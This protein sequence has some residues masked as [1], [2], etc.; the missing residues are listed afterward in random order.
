MSLLLDKVIRPEIQQLVRI[1]DTFEGRFD[2]LRL[3]KNECLQPFDEQLLNQFRINISSQDLSG[4]P[5]LGPL[6]RKLSQFVGVA[7]NQ[8]FLAA[9]SDIAIR[10][11][12][13]ACIE[14]QDNIVLHNPCYAMYKVYGQM[15]GAEVRSIPF[16]DWEPDLEEMLSQVDSKTK[17]MAVENPNGYF[18]TKPSFEQL[19]HSAS[20]LYRKDIILLIDDA[21][22]YVEN[23]QSK[24]HELIENFPNVIVTQT[25]SKSHGIAGLRMG[26][27]IGS[28]KMIEQISR[29]RP[30]H[31]VTSLTAIGAEWVLDN[32]EILLRNQNLIKENK[33][34]LIDKL[35]KIGILTKNTHAN[36]IL[37]FFPNDGKT[38]GITENLKE[39]RILMKSPFNTGVHKG[40]ARATVGTLS[41]S[42]KLVKVIK[43]ILK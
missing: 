21:Y 22:F 4:Y 11:I 6:Y 10:S 15:F 20:E 3:D 5:E 25:F 8:I 2:Y 23:S 16:Y 12:F 30:M 40:W 34:Y 26:Y 32:P 19:E 37:L 38:T 17:I 36:F 29:V 1:N 35:G 9:G 43:K 18:G 28:P 31:E 33:Q 24:T 42:K 41:D 39:N 27:L 7:E 14:R 13:D